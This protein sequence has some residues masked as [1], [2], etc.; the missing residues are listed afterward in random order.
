MENKNIAMSTCTVFV[1]VTAL[2]CLIGCAT[3]PPRT[4]PPNDNGVGSS[5]QGLAATTDCLEGRSCDFPSESIDNDAES[6]N[7]D[8]GSVHVSYNSTDGVNPVNNELKYATKNDQGNWII[9]TV[10]TGGVGWYSSLKVDSNDNVHISYY[11]IINQALK[12]ATNSSGT[13]VTTTVDSSSYDVGWSTSLV[14]D[15]N[16]KAHITYYDA[17]NQS[18]KYA[19][20]TTDFWISSTIDASADVGWVSSLAIDE[21]FDVDSLHVVYTD[22][23]YGTLKYATNASGT[24]DISTVDSIGSST[25]LTGWYLE[26]IAA[27]DIDADGNTQVGYYDINNRAM[28]HATNA[29]GS[30]VVSTIDANGDVGSS[31]SLEAYLNGAERVVLIFYYDADNEKLKY[32]INRNAGAG[33]W[34]THTPPISGTIGEEPSISVN[35]DT[36]E[37]HVT[38]LDPANNEVIYSPPIP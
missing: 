35:E 13:W 9:D 34:V 22:D 7:N 10:D 28:K 26:R 14:L 32:A 3:T 11:D 24:W 5:T 15:S 17:A 36:G 23:T 18:L 1:M 12:Y 16:D 21:S 27:L 19:T 33:A 2:I 4:E 25:I 38:S 30:W 37:F 20:N 6:P 8:D 29:T 31:I